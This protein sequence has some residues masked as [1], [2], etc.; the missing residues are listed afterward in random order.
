M[1]EPKSRFDFAGILR[2]RTTQICVPE[3]FWPY[4]LCFFL[5]PTWH[6][7]NGDLM[8]DNRFVI[9]KT[10]TVCAGKSAFET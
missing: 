7:K 6:T 5:T 4:L 10:I 1:V 3:I 8:A 9:Y 2:H